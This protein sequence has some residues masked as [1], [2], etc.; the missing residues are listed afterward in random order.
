MSI[1]DPCWFECC[2]NQPMR[3][4][5]GLDGNRRD[6]FGFDVSQKNAFSS[7]HKT[8]RFARH[9]AQSCHMPM[10]GDHHLDPLRQSTSCGVDGYIRAGSISCQVKWIHR[11]IP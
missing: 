7:S 4:S 2:C 11:S 1:N 8:I 3:K 6:D 5:D 9:V 10:T